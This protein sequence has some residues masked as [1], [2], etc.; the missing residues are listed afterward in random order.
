MKKAVKSLLT[1]ALA[2]IM[3]LVSANTSFAAF[4]IYP[5]YHLAEPSYYNA[6]SVSDTSLEDVLDTEAFVDYLIEQLKVIDCTETQSESDTPL[7]TIDISQF[8][9]PYSSNLWDILSSLIWYNSP[10]LFRIDAM[11]CSIS[12][13]KI[14]QI[15]FRENYSK[16]EYAVMLEAMYSS[17][18]KLLKNIKGNKNLTEVEKALL[19]HDRLALLCEYDYDSLQSNNVPESSYNAYGVLVLND[20]VCKGYALAYDYLLEQVG[21]QSDYCSSDELNH[22]WNIVY[23]N[24]TPYHVDVTWDDPVWDVSGR[25]RHENFLRSTN[26]FI[27]TGHIEDG[28]STIDYNN[29]PTDTTY[30]NYFWQSYETAF[31]LLNNE[32]YCFNSTDKNIELLKSED[33]SEIEV[34]KNLPYKWRQG[35]YATFIKSFSKLLCD[36]KFLYYN[37]PDTVMKFDPVTQN[38]EEI[39]KPDLTNYNDYFWIYGLN[40]KN[41]KI[42]C[43]IYS[44]PNF[45]GSVKSNYTQTCEL[46]Q[47]ILPT[48][49]NSIIDKE[50]N[51]IFSEN[52]VCKNI[53]EICK[54]SDDITYTVVASNSSVTTGYLGTGSII[55]L[56]KNDEKIAEYTIVIDGDLDGDSVCDGLDVALAEMATTNARTP[57]AIECYAANGV[58]REVIDI[59]AFQNVVNTALDIS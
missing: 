43:E 49:K 26:G 17:A 48:D 22:A 18:E 25:V 2:F 31:Q 40:I 19:L 58:A 59:S 4:L 54:I 32:I 8:E 45:D 36:G 9:I 42:I 21:I 34:I 12:S 51:I 39:F 14:S 13:G 27:E 35:E 38:E 56:Y 24:N 57:S 28:K 37:T 23:I 5:D 7:G 47:M 3:S 44:S 1:L 10:E 52:I 11:G 30:D 6:V 55:T 33:G 15:V 46:Y 50:S 16:E 53:E 29:T 41:D 20:A